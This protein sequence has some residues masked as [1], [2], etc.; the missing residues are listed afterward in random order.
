[1]RWV[2]FVVGLVSA[3]VAAPVPK[4]IRS[5]LD[6]IKQAMPGDW[7]VTERTNKPTGRWEES[8]EFDDRTACQTVDT[9]Q[10]EQF[11]F[12][13]RLTQAGGVVGLDLWVKDGKKVLAQTGIVRR[14]A[15]G[16]LVWRLTG[17]RTF[18]DGLPD[19]ADMPARPTW[20]AD[21]TSDQFTEYRLTRRPER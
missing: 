5:E 1:M 8:Y 18:R 17:E 3:G 11:N 4:S 14:T 2:V 15:D 16:E 21:A 9:G 19:P 13:Y 12:R 10:V 7:D 6:H 20:A